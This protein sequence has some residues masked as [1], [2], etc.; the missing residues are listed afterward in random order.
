MH[1][2]SHMIDSE[3]FDPSPSIFYSVSQNTI[4][5]FDIDYIILY[6]NSLYFN[7]IK[8]EIHQCLFYSVWGFL[9]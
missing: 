3:L 5:I 7:K 9:K 1:L 8:N 4:G 2:T 6:V